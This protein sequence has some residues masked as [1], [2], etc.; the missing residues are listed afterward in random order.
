[1]QKVLYSLCLLRNNMLSILIHQKI[2][3]SNT[4]HIFD[5]SKSGYKIYSFCGR[6]E[7]RIKSDFI[8]TILELEYI[9]IHAAY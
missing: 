9:Y 1:M 7:L 8:E 6:S 5:T 4:L 2:P 3:Q